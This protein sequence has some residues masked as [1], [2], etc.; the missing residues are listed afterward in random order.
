V[1]Y[2]EDLRGKKQGQGRPRC[3]HA[4]VIPRGGTRGAAAV[5]PA[6][7][8]RVA[9]DRPARRRWDSNAHQPRPNPSG[10]V[11]NPQV[12]RGIRRGRQPLQYAPSGPVRGSP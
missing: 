5:R 12:N 4:T 11:R 3:G 1:G 6:P 10:P 2:V 8:L 7:H 9:F